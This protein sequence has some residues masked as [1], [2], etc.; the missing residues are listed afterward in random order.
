V[1]AIARKKTDGQLARREL[2]QSVEHFKQAATHAARGTGATVGPKYDAARGRVTPAASRAKDVASSGWER[3]LKTLA[4]LAAATGETARKTGKDAQKSSQKSKNN[5][6]QLQKKTNKA[7][8]RKQGGRKAGKLTGFLVAGVAVGAAAAYVLKRRQREQWDEYDPSRPITSADTTATTGADDA[9]YEPA[10]FEPATFEPA[11]P[12]GTSTFAAP[13][14]Q[15]ASS[16]T[17]YGEAADPALPAGDITDQTSSQ[18]H[19]P[20]V[21]RMAK[22][23]TNN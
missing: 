18:L 5:A 19:S 3:A 16:T 7:L 21:A 20:E 6:K 13:Q 1:F 4:P 23:T 11:E 8:N 14:T 9:A 2:S 17:V 12:A 22:G 15:T 10:A